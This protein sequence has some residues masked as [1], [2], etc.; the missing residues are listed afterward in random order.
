MGESLLPALLLVAPS[1][2]VS[3]HWGHHCGATMPMYGVTLGENPIQS[4]TSD[5]G[6]IDMA[7]F[8]QASLLETRVGLR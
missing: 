6:T 1:S 4:W 8:L 5:G 3:L 7:P 2:M